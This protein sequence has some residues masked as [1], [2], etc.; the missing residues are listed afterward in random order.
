MAGTMKIRGGQLGA[1]LC[2]DAAVFLRVSKTAG[3]KAAC[4]LQSFPY[5]ADQLGILIEMKCF[6]HKNLPVN[7]TVRGSR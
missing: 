6:F 7:Y 1:E 5:D 3:T 2:T 4:A